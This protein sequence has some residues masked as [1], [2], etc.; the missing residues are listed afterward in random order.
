MPS[1]VPDVY[2]TSGLD[3]D[4]ANQLALDDDGNFTGETIG[5]V[6][7]ADMKADLLMRIAQD[8]GITLD[9]VLPLPPAE[10]N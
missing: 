5:P 6:V 4:Y 2:F 3:Y 1:F 7:N 8:E 9:Q 10:K